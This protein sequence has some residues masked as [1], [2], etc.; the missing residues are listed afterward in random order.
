MAELNLSKER[1]E[2]LQKIRATLPSFSQPNSLEKEL[3]KLPTEKPFR[4]FVHN[5]VFSATESDVANI[6][7]VGGE[8]G[9]RGFCFVDFA[10]RDDLAKALERNDAPLC[11]RPLSVRIADPNTSDR[12]GGFGRDR[13]GGG[14]RTGGGYDRPRGS[15][16]PASLRDE[17]PEPTSGGTGEWLR[18]STVGRATE[19][20]TSFGFNRSVPTEPTPDRPRLNLLPRTVPITS[21]KEEPSRDPK[22]FGLA[23]PVDTTFKDR[24]IE[25][26]LN[27]CAQ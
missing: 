17:L 18:G 16:R 15:Y 9:S 5:M 14:R 6:N 1:A 10:T 25:E 21:G 12:S 8:T 3:A 22:I 4:A 20:R 13:Y 24:E 2:E 7:L 26:R 19:P 23:K 11:G 27:Q